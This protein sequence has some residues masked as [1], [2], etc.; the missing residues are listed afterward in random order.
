MR[1][2][3]VA[4]TGITGKVDLMLSQSR[5]T[6]NCKQAAIGIEAKN[7][8]LFRLMIGPHT[9]QKHRAYFSNLTVSREVSSDFYK[10]T[11]SH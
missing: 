10:P 1:W 3:G 4:A 7:I 9:I 2:G 11:T 8:A 5:S 6:V